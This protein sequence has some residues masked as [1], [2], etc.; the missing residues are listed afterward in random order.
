[1]RTLIQGGT[2]ATGSDLFVA[3]VLLDGESVAAVGVDLGR[4]GP[5][6]PHGGRPR[7]VRPAGGVTPTC[8]CS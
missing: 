1:M 7:H 3:D 5:F 4:L 2:V 6:D 8:T